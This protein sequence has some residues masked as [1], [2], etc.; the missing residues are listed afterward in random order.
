MKKGLSVKI[1]SIAA[2]AIG[3]MPILGFMLPL[4]FTGCKHVEGN[5]ASINAPPVEKAAPLNTV[6][7]SR[8]IEPE[9]L[10]T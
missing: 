6:T 9:W 2:V 5:Y 4:L 8:K 1:R 3:F 7:V 10:K